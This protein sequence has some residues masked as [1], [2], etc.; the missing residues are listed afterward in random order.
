MLAIVGDSVYY[1]GF[2]YFGNQL[3]LFVAGVCDV[4]SSL[5]V[6]L[7]LLRSDRT[8][9]SACV[10]S[11]L[12][13]I[14]ALGCFFVSRFQILRDEMLWNNFCFFQCL[15]LRSTY[16]PIDNVVSFPAMVFV[17]NISIHRLPWL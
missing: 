17:S 7:V 3:F 13:L 8:K 4:F 2:F 1:G 14:V 16:V 5:T 12:L 15:M 10:C 9:D 11:F 6:F